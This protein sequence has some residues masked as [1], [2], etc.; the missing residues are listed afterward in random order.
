MKKFLKI[1]AVFI[2]ILVTGSIA[3]DCF[4]SYRLRHSESRMFKAWSYIYYDETDYDIV[5][6]G[7]SRAWVQYDPEIIDSVLSTKTLNLGIDGSSINRQI[8]KYKAYCREHGKVPKMLIQNI[9]FVTIGFTKNLE[10]E[11]FFPYFFFD[12]QL[13]EDANIYEDFSSIERYA[14]LFRY[15]G[16]RDVIK[17]ALLNEPY[18]DMLNRGYCGR[19]LGWDGSMFEQQDTLNV[20]RDSVALSLFDNFISEVVEEG[21][22]VVFVFAPIYSEVNDKIPD[23]SVMYDI[24]NGVAEKYHIPTLNYNEITLC[25][26]TAYFYNATHLNRTGSEI[27]TRTL[28]KD[29][30]SLKLMK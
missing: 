23:I 22:K 15:Y 17:S 20:S 13:E 7:G 12:R 24:F 8:I 9:D 19:D 26:D 29:I 4:I 2:A 3:L 14:P 25:N 27:F 30:D 5:I 6:N 1:F 10:R 21:T 28:A 18:G 11:Q 16:Y